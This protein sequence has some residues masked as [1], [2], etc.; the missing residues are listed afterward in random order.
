MLP[1]GDDGLSSQAPI[2]AVSPAWISAAT[3][4]VRLASHRNIAH[5]VPHFSLDGERQKRPAQP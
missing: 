5:N 4:R 3:I 1:S 2:R